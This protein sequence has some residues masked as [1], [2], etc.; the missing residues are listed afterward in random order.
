MHA[1]SKV[2]K[3]YITTFYF[4]FSG[5]DIFMGKILVDD[6]QVDIFSG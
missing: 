1:V 2:E 6:L 3:R 4:Y 5:S